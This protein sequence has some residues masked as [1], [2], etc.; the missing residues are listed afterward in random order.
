MNT[1]FKKKRV[2]V[3]NKLTK[4]NLLIELFAQNMLSDIWYMRP[5]RAYY[6]IGWN[7]TS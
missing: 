5:R 3:E 1:K 2:K 7:D 4:S 6:L